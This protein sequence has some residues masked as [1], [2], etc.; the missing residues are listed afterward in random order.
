[1]GH[2][3]LLLSHNTDVSNDGI[4][5]SIMRPGNGGCLDFYN[6]TTRVKLIDDLFL[7]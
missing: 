5:E 6:A 4:C 7:N 2:C 1:L 3:Y